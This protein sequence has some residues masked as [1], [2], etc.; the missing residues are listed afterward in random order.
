MKAKKIAEEVYE[1]KDFL[2]KEELFQVTKI[3][4]SLSESDWLSDDTPLNN[5]PSD[6]WYGK[7]V[8]F[9]KNIIFDSINKK[10]KNL[11]QSFAKYPESTSLQRY[12]SGQSIKYHR[13]IWN[14]DSPL[15]VS[16][17]VLLYYNDDYSGGELDYEELGLMVKPGPG[18]LYIH[19]GK[20]LHGTRPVLGNGTRYFSTVFVHGTKSEPAKLKD[21][22][23]S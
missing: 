12:T 14:I 19:G 15:H 22:L 18:S 4:E 7:T 1:I 10:I 9:Q 23:F 2:T 11:F 8:D 16:Y 20:V 3:I 21:S 6:F 5:D 13:D 17:G